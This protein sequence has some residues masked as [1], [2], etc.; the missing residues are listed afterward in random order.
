MIEV[1]TIK[2]EILC[3]EKEKIETMDNWQLFNKN[4]T[5]TKKKKYRLCLCLRKRAPVD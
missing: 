2:K 4:K 1:L 3:I 5:P